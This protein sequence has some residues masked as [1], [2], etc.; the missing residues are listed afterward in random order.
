MNKK[1]YLKKIGITLIILSVIALLVIFL[2]YT[3]NSKTQILKLGHTI[4]STLY[5]TNYKTKDIE[6][7]Y[8]NYP[9]TNL[10]YYNLQSE[11]SEYVTLLK[12]EL[13]VTID[14][15]WK[16]FIHY[17]NTDEENGLIQFTYW[18]GDEIE[19]SKIIIGF[20]ENNNVNELHYY[21]L[22]KE[23]NENELIQTLSNFKNNTRQEKYNLSKDQKYL[24]EEIKYHFNYENNRLLYTYNLFFEE[25]GAINNDIG[26]QYIIN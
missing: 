6:S 16:Y 10:Q 13:N 12:K 20:I 3:L 21:Y 14:N 4:D 2:N 26:S 19:T 18:I 5:N 17:Y 8:I 25:N 9:E 23:V 24:H 7:F 11:I 15:H 22:D 1:K